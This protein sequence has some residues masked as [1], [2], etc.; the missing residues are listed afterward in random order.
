MWSKSH[1]EVVVKV[2]TL[3]LPLLFSILP[4]VQDDVKL[5]LVVVVR[6]D[7]IVLDI[8]QVG[9]IVLLVLCLVGVVHVVQELVLQLVDIVLDVAVP[10]LRL[11]DRV[12]DVVELVLRLVDR[13][14]DAV[15]DEHEGLSHHAARSDARCYC[16]CD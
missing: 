9:G 12:L 2:A 11:V 4:V 16:S 15:V 5:L 7:D 3:D 1:V 6:H 10:E 13:V 14:L 8:V